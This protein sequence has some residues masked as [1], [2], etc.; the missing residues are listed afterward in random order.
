M[1]KNV[2]LWGIYNLL[3]I[4]SGIVAYHFFSEGKWF[5]TL[6]FV[7]LMV[8]FVTRVYYSL[9]S[10]VSKAEKIILSIRRKDFSLF[11][12]EEGNHLVD[13]SIRLYYQSKDEQLSQ[14]SYKLLYES[15]LD[16]METGLM[17]LSAQHEKWDVFYVN[18]AF[19]E[20]LQVPKYN[21][22]ELYASKVPD[23][24]NIIEDTGYMSSQDFFD[25]SIHGNSKQSFSLRTKQLKNTQHHFYIITLESVQKII[26]QKEKMAWNN[27]MKVISHELLNTLTPVNSLI[28]NLEY[29]S[30]QET[31]DKEDQQ[32]MKDSLMIINSKSKQLLNF[33]DDYRQVAEL[34]KPVLASV[35][36]KN[37]IASAASILKSTLTQQHIQMIMDVED[38]RVSAD[39]KMI[40]RSLINLY[41]NAIVAVSEKKHKVIKTSVRSHNNR[42]VVSITDNGTGIK[43]EIKDKIFLPFFTTRAG[44]SGIGLTL[45]KSIM[46]A[47]G[48][49]LNYK[50]LEEGS[51]FE[52]WFLK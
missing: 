20:I 38:F 36:L 9:I 15:I 52:L 14:S 5:N 37:V 50:A 47:H 49:Y 23:F 3:A 28:Q 32:E 11:P 27:L 10:Q 16:H 40:E 1:N 6:L 8:F 13:N 39:E 51:S 35:S 7:G 4:T 29:I 21:S 43:P 48:G 17:I 26:E 42:I 44:G 24:Y 33:V 25:I 30:N 46:Q 41:L 22:W 18:G 12:T 34:P 31:I 2:Y 45:T 19:L